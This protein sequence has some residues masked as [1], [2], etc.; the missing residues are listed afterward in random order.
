[1][2]ASFCH[3]SAVLIEKINQFS[4]HEEMK[5]FIILLGL[6]ISISS[7]SQTPAANPTATDAPK[8]KFGATA[9]RLFLA[10]EYVRKHPAPDF[11]AL[12]PYY[13]P[14]QSGASCSLA[15]ATM[16]LNAARAHKGLTA[17]DELATEK[18]VIAKQPNDQWGK[19]VGEHGHGVALDEA[20]PFIE[21]AFQSFGMKVSVEVIHVDES[22]AM[23]KTVHQHLVENEKSDKDFI[24]VNFLQS[25]Y[26][27]DPEGS[28]GH[29][30]PVGAYDEK[31]KKVLI[32]D[33]DRQ[34]YEPYWVTEDTLVKGM[35]TTDKGASKTRGLIHI[36]ILGEK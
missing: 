16:V 25:E 3:L 15:S 13:W 35:A 4:E 32:R 31:A 26:T 10:N 12:M 23:K 30:A 9:T 5:P 27:G 19:A 7:F 34:Y 6:V 29:L 33:P 11:W 20:K 17:S 24:I 18:N 21:N 8:P 22:A 2:G 14:Q 1:M 36:R 28:V